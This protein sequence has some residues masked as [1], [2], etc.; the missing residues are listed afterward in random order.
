MNEQDR[1]IVISADCHGGA[2]LAGYREYLDPGYRE[3]FD[4]W[5]A[6]YTMPYEDMD[7]EDGSRNWDSD[8]RLR[9]LEDDGIVAEVMYPNTV[10]PFFIRSSLASAQAAP[11]TAE[12]LRLRWAGLRAH[13]RWLA[14]FCAQ[15]KGRRAGIFQVLLQ[16]IDQAVQ[17]IRWAAGAGLRGGVLLPGAPP[18]SGVPPL[19][20][21]DYYDKLWAACAEFGMPVNCHSGGAAPRTGYR[22]ED[23]VFFLLEMK[24]WDKRMIRHLILGGVLER[25]PALT[26]VVTEAG[27]GWIPNELQEM[28]AFAASM[29]G[30]AKS[31]TYESSNVIGGLTM[32]P[33]EY[34][35]RQCYAGASFMHPAETAIRDAIGVS[36]IMWGSDYPHIESSFPYSKAAIQFCFDGVPE[37]EAAAML[38]G[39]AARVYGFSADVLRAAAAR[40]G[41]GRAE[42]MSGIDPSAVPADAVRCPA[43]AG[44][45]GTSLTY[46]SDNR[47]ARKAGA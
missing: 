2:A 23:D 40:V 13:N 11:Q 8:R 1:H 19:Y 37:H 44:V 33:S 42:V 3:E 7:G 32:R 31:V 39:N 45:G 46:M 18:G 41:P 27:V 4:R 10:P 12:D 15:A 26:V 29:Y 30:S 22:P 47:T 36:T 21:H 17:E 9:D 38:G 28:D 6:S 14:D 24:W 43:F 34:W 5:A 25:H 16:D 20:Y 35:H